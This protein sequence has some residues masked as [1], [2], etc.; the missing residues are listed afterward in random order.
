M[1]WIRSTGWLV[2]SASIAAA[3]TAVMVGAEATAFA[4]D[5][6]YQLPFN[7][8]NLADGWG[9]TK[10][11]ANP[12]RGVD[13]PQAA[14]TPIPVVADGIVRLRATS[15]C[16]GNV[17]VVEHADGMFSGY[18]HLIRPSPIAEGTRVS[19]GQI[20]ANVGTTGTCTT[21]NHLH[22]TMAPTLGGWGSGTTVDPYKYIQEH[23]TC[24]CDRSGGG[25]TF[26]CDGPNA[27]KSCVNVDEP[28]DPNSW[29]D[30]FLCS[31]TDLG[32]AWSA[33]G[34]I[35]GKE[36]TNV[37]EAAETYASSWAD[38]YVCVDNDATVSLSWSSAGPVSGKTCFNWNEPNDPDSWSDN[39]LCVEARSHFTAGAF[40]FSSSGAVE[41]KTCVN[42]DEPLDDKTWSDN[43]FCSDAPVGLQWS[44]S[45]PIDGLRCTNVA[46]PAEHVAEAWADNYLCVPPDSPYEF[47][48]SVDGPVP[49]KD[50]VRWYEAAD[51][52]GSWGDNYLCANT[53]SPETASPGVDDPS[54]PS[55]PNGPSDQGARLADESASSGCSVRQGALAKSSG[56]SALGLVAG[57]GL[58]L[59]RRRRAR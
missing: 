34:P 20:I 17:V 53:L 12:H 27:G 46:E 40:T 21:G 18:A 7:N 49:G 51:L 3:V 24:S 5:V 13:F 52:A 57:L 33:S 43:F 47:Q 28:D 38:N 22:L 16:L 4:E 39:F 2:K 15:S 19:K 9:S 41:G 23:K 44:A 37:H 50:C 42:V 26:S 59:R 6:C 35:R 1:N 25:L 10:G 14:N 36:C 45:G 55:N 8:P 31:D 56:L 29:S 48:F 11:R 54:D 30:N 58:V 32:L